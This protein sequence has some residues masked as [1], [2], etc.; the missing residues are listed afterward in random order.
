MA[1][2]EFNE[3]NSSEEND[4]EKLKALLGPGAIEH[5]LRQSIQACWMFLPADKRSVDEVERQVRR[6]IDRIFKNLRDD[7][8]SFSR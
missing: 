8:Q 2:S 6:L 7:E 1:F 3:F 5:G 4:P